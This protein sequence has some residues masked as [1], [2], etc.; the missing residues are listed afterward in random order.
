MCYAY[1]EVEN[2]VLAAVK[3]QFAWFFFKHFYFLCISSLTIFCGKPLFNS[4]VINY[5]QIVLF[6]KQVT[7]A[8]ERYFEFIVSKHVYVYMMPQCITD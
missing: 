6:L 1:Y 5:V 2:I 7:A 3:W 4:Y 8:T